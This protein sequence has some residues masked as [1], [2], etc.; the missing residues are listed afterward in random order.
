MKKTIKYTL[1]TFLF[2]II[3]VSLFYI[4]ISQ[5]KTETDKVE[6]DDSI[7]Y[8]PT[9]TPAETYDFST[10]TVRERAMLGLSTT[11]KFQV[12]RRSATGTPIDYRIIK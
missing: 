8:V 10:M 9:S 2:L 11:L 3:I 7:I 5:Y 6:K 4:F 12:I 1:L